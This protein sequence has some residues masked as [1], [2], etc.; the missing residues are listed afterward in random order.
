MIPCPAADLST[1]ACYTS[2]FA[3]T[4]SHAGVFMLSRAVIALLICLLLV[5]CGQKGPLYL[6]EAAP[7]EAAVEDD[8][9][10]D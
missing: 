5:A 3:T 6:P 1:D 7:V 2:A 8:E 9:D 4:V 10:R